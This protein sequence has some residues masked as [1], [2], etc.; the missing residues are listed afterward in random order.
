LIPINLATICMESFLYGLFFILYGTSTYVLVRQGQRKMA[1][2]GQ[3]S[4]MNSVYKAPMFLAAHLIFLTV[5]GHWILTVYRLFEA[6][7]NYRG[8]TQALFYY[9][10]IAFTSEVVRIAL[11]VSTVLVSDAMIIYRLYIIWGYNKL[12]IIPPVLTWCG[13]MGISVGV[14]WQFSQYKLGDTVYRGP[15]GHW[16]TADGL[17]TLITNVYCSACISYRVFRARRE[18]RR[19]PSLASPN[20]LSA[21]AIL[22]ESAAL[23]TAWNAVFLASF[24]RANPFQFTAIDLWSPI[25]G[26]AFML[27][28]LRV[29]LGW[30]QR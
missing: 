25:A 26:I 1:A 21:L 8:G 15:F 9:A 3:Q 24:Q 7:V 17:T 18:A 2:E 29:A 4:R 14:C 12:V 28:N 19:Y 10:S 23:H 11:L 20:L 5:T 16:I 13:L 27:I 6:F 22:V 30:A